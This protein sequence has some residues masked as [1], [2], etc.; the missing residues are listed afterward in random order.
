M[1]ESATKNCWRI[2]MRSYFASSLFQSQSR[3]T[4]RLGS[5]SSDP[6]VPHATRSLSLCILQRSA[7]HTHTHT[8][9]RS[10]F[11]AL[12]R[13][14]NSVAWLHDKFADA[15]KR[16]T[17][18]GRPSPSLAEHST[19]V[20][21]RMSACRHVISGC[22]AR[23]HRAVRPSSSTSVTTPP[24]ERKQACVRPLLARRLQRVNVKL[25][26]WLTGHLQWRHQPCLRHDRRL[27]R[28]TPGC[29]VSSCRSSFDDRSFAD[30]RP[31][32][33]MER[34]I[35]VLAGCEQF[36]Y[37]RKHS[38]VGVRRTVT[39]FRMD[40]ALHHFVASRRWMDGHYTLMSS[41]TSPF[42]R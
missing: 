25:H 2:R 12:P 11:L 5:D 1:Q 19:C 33:C 23:Q 41:A 32:T 40:R 10:L 15:T 30:A 6:P 35:N 29:A 34:S 16:N 18:R 9:T 27:F 13:C 21:N 22:P 26:S 42:S 39:A 38:Y 3:P 36:S 37:Y 14:L 20:D 28:S 8:H 31:G 4:D 24:S 7:T 17:A